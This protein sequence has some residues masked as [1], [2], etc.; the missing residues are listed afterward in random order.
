MLLGP[1]SSALSE[2]R[3]SNLKTKNWCP[4]PD[5][6]LVFKNVRALLLFLLLFFGRP[7][8]QKSL[9][10]CQFRLGG[11][12]K[13]SWRNGGPMMQGQRHRR[14]LHG[15]RSQGHGFAAKIRGRCPILL[16]PPPPPPPPLLPPRPPL[17]PAPPPLL[18]CSSQ[19]TIVQQ[20]IIQ[21]ETRT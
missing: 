13:A 2:A 10:N 11:S 3:F 17:L 15:W 12:D 16:S 19:R 8:T 4:G 5:R 18:L 6:R 1:V 14:S 9:Y 20:P 21:C 7:G